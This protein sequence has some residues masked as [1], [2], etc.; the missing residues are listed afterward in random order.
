M[1]N[2]YPS[3]AVLRSL[4][5]NYLSAPGTPTIVLRI[6]QLN[7]GAVTKSVG[8]P[9]WKIRIRRGESATTE[10]VGTRWTTRAGGGG[11]ISVRR[12]G[13]GPLPQ[14]QDQWYLYEFWGDLGA[15]PG[16]L[17]DPS[18]KS[19]TSVENEVKRIAVSKIRQA[20]TSL[21]GLVAAGE[22]GQTVRM[23]TSRARSLHVGVFGYLTTLRK[24]VKPRRSRRKGQRAATL[25]REVKRVNRLVAGSWLEAQYGWKPLVNDIRDGAL[26]L[27][28]IQ[29]YRAPSVRIHAAA[30]SAEKSAGF[31]ATRTN[32]PL[33]YKFST[34]STFE[35][36]FKVYGV[37]HSTPRGVKVF[38]F[39]V[40]DEFG[41]KLSE[42]VP[43]IWELI[44][45]SF[46][47]DYFSNIGQIIDA[48]SLNASNVGWLNSG[49][50]K[51]SKFTS[52]PH[53]VA[54][55]TPPGGQ[56][57]TDQRTGVGG[58]FEITREYVKRSTFTPG[59]LVPSL[60][61]RVPGTSTKW[62]NMAA[63]L[64]TSRATSRYLSKIR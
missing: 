18:L 54:F 24:V 60:E 26:A 38:N 2:K 10:L 22:M 27:S 52:V 6:D 61:F 57:D 12:H 9:D 4:I 46:L 11:H 42:F 47:V 56:W 16:T 55:Q 59:H 1:A 14:R 50:K 36:E 23:I 30:S 25:E 15:Y 3:G 49:V 41:L 48:Y 7:S 51:V 53:S 37:V 63:L 43:T 40:L 58:P 39:P 8:F 62:L 32:G 34:S 21:R 17:D 45:Y 44:P 5:T 35:Y 13:F 33:S 28:R 29:T 19:I 20:Q 31:T 64:A